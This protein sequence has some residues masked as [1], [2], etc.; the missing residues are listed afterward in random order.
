MQPGHLATGAAHGAAVR[1]IAAS[2]AA[3]A[4]AALPACAADA[5]SDRHERRLTRLVELAVGEPGPTADAAEDALVAA[6]RAAILHVETGLYDAEPDGRRRLVQVLTRIGDREG[7][8]ILA[9]LA[10]HDPDPDVRADAA[11]GVRALAGGPALQAG[12][13]P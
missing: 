2:T 8:P 12:S 1:R 11:A 7:R 3:A 9:Y 5:C 6:G 4:L 13:S 10:A